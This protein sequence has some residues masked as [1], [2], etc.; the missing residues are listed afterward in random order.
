MFSFLIKWKKA[1]SKGRHGKLAS[2]PLS[3]VCTLFFSHKST[4]FYT[5]SH[6]H[7]CT[8]SSAHTLWKLELVYTLNRLCQKE[9]GFLFDSPFADKTC[10]NK[11]KSYNLF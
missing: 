3:Q 5:H 1:F 9:V 10:D 8:H 4:H 6:T 11:V 7:T 2:A